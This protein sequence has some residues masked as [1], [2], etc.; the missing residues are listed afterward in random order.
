M[1]NIL[2]IEG[3]R[4]QFTQEGAQPL[5]IINGLSLRVG[6]GEF[7][8]LV[9]E[10]GAG[11]SITLWTIMKLLPKAMQFAGGE[12][13]FDGQKISEHPEKNFRRFRGKEISIISQNPFGSLNPIKRIG[14]QLVEFFRE[15]NDVTYKVATKRVLEELNAVG[16]ADPERRFNSFPNE[17]SGGMA[18]RVLIAAAMINRPKL[19]LADE[20]TTGLD[21]T[22]Q[23]QILELIKS[24]S[25]ELGTS[26]LFVTHDLGIIAQYCDFVSV[27]F[28]G[29]IVESGPPKEVFLNPQH[30]YTRQLLDTTRPN[31]KKFDYKDD[32]T[33][34]DLSRIH[35][36]CNYNYRCQFASIEC[37]QP[38]NTSTLNDGHIVRCH[39]VGRLGE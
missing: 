15:H 17:L 20:P 27:M 8:G 9:G 22:I 30:P 11:K 2:E 36:G 18:Q 31:E 23:A 33:P 35:G 16:I 1:T 19:V 4:V 6:K 5:K 32:G 29:D 7:H 39:K 10:T 34:P 24:R 3:L 38:L 21:V 25:A 37:L 28:A 14:E 12:I 26:V 13:A